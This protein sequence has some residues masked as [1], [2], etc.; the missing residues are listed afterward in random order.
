MG[1]VY[2]LQLKLSMGN[3]HVHQPWMMVLVLVGRRQVGPLISLPRLAVVDD[4]RMPMGMSYGVMFMAGKLM[5]SAL[6][7]LRLAGS[8]RAAGLA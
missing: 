3:M 8:L 1:L 2:V 5:A 6:L 7:S 4:M